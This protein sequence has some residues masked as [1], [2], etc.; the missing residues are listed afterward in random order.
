M[1]NPHRSSEEFGSSTTSGTSNEVCRLTTKIPPFWP[2][3]PIIWFAQVEGQFLNAGITADLTKYNYV[4]AQLDQT[5]LREVKD[6]IINPPL[7]GKYEK[8]KEVLIKR[9]SDSNEKKMKQLLM[10]EELGDRKPSQFLRHLQGLAGPHVPEELIRTIWTSRLPHN[11]QTV[12]AS[13]TKSTL[14]D[15]ADLADKVN[16]IASSSNH[17]ASTSSALITTSDVSSLESLTREVAEL[18]RELRKLS[19][20]SSDRHTRQQSRGRGRDRA[21]SKSRNRSD[22]SYRKYPTCW[23]HSKYGLEAK[24]C[25]KPC[26]FKSEN[27]MG[28]R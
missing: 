21:H 2:E 22:S 5:H 1:A 27:T 10:H 17:V 7:S 12:I 16:E 6:I 11:I 15:I 18:R 9:L 23:Y 8:L 14:E 28:G 3:E 20:Q 4:I 26:D 19:T 25:V 13:Q 24:K